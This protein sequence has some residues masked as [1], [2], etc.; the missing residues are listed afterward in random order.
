M[1]DDNYRRAALALMLDEQAP[2]LKV[3][4]WICHAMPVC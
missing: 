3:Q 2:T 4:G 1:Q